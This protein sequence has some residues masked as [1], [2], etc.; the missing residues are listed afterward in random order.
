MGDGGSPLVPS[1][2]MVWGCGLRRSDDDSMPLEIIVNFCPGCGG[3]LLLAAARTLDGVQVADKSASR[4]PIT[5][6]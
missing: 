4:E 1:M 3:S 6:V 2:T 5:G